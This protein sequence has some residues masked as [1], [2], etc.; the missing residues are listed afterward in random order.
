LKLPNSYSRPIFTELSDEQKWAA[1]RS[2]RRH[3]ER[4]QIKL[5]GKSGIIVRKRA[6]VDYL[7]AAREEL[8]RQ[9]A[10]RN[11][12]G[13]NARSATFQS[14]KE[15]L[16]ATFLELEAFRERE[17]AEATANDWEPPAGRITAKKIYAAYTGRF[18]G[19]EHALELST[20]QTYI[21][22]FKKLR[23]RR[24]EVTVS[25]SE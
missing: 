12:A 3:A 5:D 17:F 20:V 2:I 19:P 23:H 7:K 4:L 22:E 21:R 11:Q 14:R 8:L 25:I 9:T 18:P 6:K 16:I 24:P 13:G 10:I 1:Y 15:N